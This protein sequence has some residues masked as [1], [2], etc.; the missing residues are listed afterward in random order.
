MSRRH[1]QIVRR[2]AEYFIEDLDSRNGTFLNGRP[3]KRFRIAHLDVISMGPD[4]DLIFLESGAAVPPVPRP[5]PVRAAVAW[6][7]GPFA[8]QQQEIPADAGLLLGRGGGFRGC[9][10]SRGAMRSSPC[11]AIV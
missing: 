4:V 11:A 8:G 5:Q 7:D 10:R 1:A 6:V 2:G 3:V 9:L